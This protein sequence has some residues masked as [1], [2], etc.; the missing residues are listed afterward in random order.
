VGRTMSI[1]L[2]GTT[3]ITTPDIDSV[4]APDLDGSNITGIVIP[5]IF[6]PTVVSGT[7]QVLDVGSH[8]FF[9]GGILTG[10]TS[11]SFTSVPT[12][13][14]WTYTYEGGATGSETLDGA[15][16]TSKQLLVGDD[17]QG[18]VF[19]N[20]GTKL[21]VI[22]A[23]T[24]AVVEYAL[25]TAYDIETATLTTTFSVTS[26]EAAP[27][28]LLFNADGTKM[29]IVGFYGGDGPNAYSGVAVYLLSTG[30]DI[31]TASFNTRVSAQQH[32]YAMTFNSDGSKWYVSRHDG[33]TYQYSLSTAYELSSKSLT[34]SFALGGGSALKGLLFS[35]DGTK[36]FLTQGS[37]IKEFA[38]STAFEIA[39]A[40]LV[41][42]L[43]FAAV[44]TGPT[45]LMWGAT[46]ANLL[47]AGTSFD[48]VTLV[49]AATAST[50]T[51]PSS[52][53]NPNVAKAAGPTA[54]SIMEF[55]TTDGGTT[56]TI[57]GGSL[58]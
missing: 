23:G 25:S 7:S 14:K 17:P 13:A 20:D 47:V 43:T 57:I 12:N 40:T 32:M 42:S 37:D 54:K 33:I 16:I 28:D 53:S 36:V 24:D 21:F 44:D 3:G 41:R 22:R 49:S 4:A 38:L 39:T 51:L 31:S 30:F 34:N 6:D 15:S 50:F 27:Y 29:Y 55:A 1:T 19:N 52:V 8:N 56:V 45:G 58:I 18:L 11:L 26:Q 2:N 5:P 10:D 48:N 46:G 9:D 35:Q